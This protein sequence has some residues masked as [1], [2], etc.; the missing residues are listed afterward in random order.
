MYEL[1]IVISFL[2]QPYVRHCV[3]HIRKQHNVTAITA[4]RLLSL[5]DFQLICSYMYMRYS[6]RFLWACDFVIIIKLQTEYPLFVTKIASSMISFIINIY[7][8][9][10]IF[11]FFSVDLFLPALPVCLPHGCGTERLP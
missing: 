9:N 4:K 5:F 10:S 6:L 8:N 3:R 2:A 7:Y 11:F 1:P